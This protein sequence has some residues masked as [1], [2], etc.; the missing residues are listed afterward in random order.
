MV[1][2]MS[3]WARESMSARGWARE[4]ERVSVSMMAT[5]WHARVWGERESQQVGGRWRRENPH[6]LAFGARARVG[7]KKK[8]VSREKEKKSPQK[9]SLI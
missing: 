7:D 4:S 6:A 3:A 5:A 9:N 2:S 1:V 8:K